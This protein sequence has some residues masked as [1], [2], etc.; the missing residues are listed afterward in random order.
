[1][2]RDSKP[3]AAELPDDDGSEA[4]RTRSS[5]PQLRS[6]VVHSMQNDRW[7]GED[8]AADRHVGA[9]QGLERDWACCGIRSLVNEDIDL[10]RSSSGSAY[11]TLLLEP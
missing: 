3:G 5:G 11:H 10:H 7:E 1:M 4:E 2:L 6:T 8:V 9:Y